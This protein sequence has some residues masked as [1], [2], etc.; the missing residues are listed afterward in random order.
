MNILL[1][2][3]K[4]GAIGASLAFLLLSFQLLKNEQALKTKDG[5]P[6][7]PRPLFLASIGN[8]RRA[9]LTFLIVGAFLEFFLSQ[10]PIVL[11]ALNQSILKNDLTRVRFTDWEFEPEHKKI[12]FGFEENHLDSSLYVAPAIKNKYAVYVGVRKKDAT[13]AGQ[14]QYDLVLGPYAISNQSNL[15]K[16]LTDPELA[17]L[18][19]G[20]IQFTAF[21][22]LKPELGTVEIQ[23]PFTP[24]AMPSQVTLFNSA[25][26]CIQ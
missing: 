17:A 15:E 3:V 23:R 1:D 16:Q 7:E 20:C 11:A 6:A 22:I 26:A 25:T 12:S 14:G 5:D 2:L 13:A 21:G 10:G 19:Q 24:A 8:F 9:A 18:G 4:L